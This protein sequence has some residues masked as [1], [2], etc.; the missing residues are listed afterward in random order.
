MPLT[1]QLIKS[2]ELR[3]NKANDKN[4]FS[5]KIKKIKYK[6]RSK[7]DPIKNTSKTPHF[8]E[9]I[10]IIEEFSNEDLAILEKVKNKSFED[11]KIF[12]LKLK[13]EEAAKQSQITE[14][15][16]YPMIKNRLAYNL[17]HQQEGALKILRDLDGRALLADEVG[18]GKTITAGMV[19]K[20]CIVRGFVRRALI[21]TPPSLVNQWKDE[22]STKFDLNFKEIN[23][24]TEWENIEL[25]IASIDKV[26]NFNVKANKFKHSKAHEIYWDIIIIDE[27]HKLKD[28]NTFRWKFIDRLQK[29]RLLLLTAT[30]FQN[31]LIE[32]YNLLSLLRRGHLG[33][34]SEFRSSFL[35]DGDER[36]PL[37]PQE[38]KRKLSEVMIRRRR[39]E[40]KG[41]HYMRRIPKIQSVELTW[42]ERRAYEEVMDLLLVHYLDFNGEPI[43][44]NLAA[45]SILPKITSSSKSSIE[46]LENLV[47]NPKYHK[48]TQ[49]I[50]ERIIEDFKGIGKDTKIESLMNLINEINKKDKGTKILL[51]TKH[52]ITLKYIAGILKKQRFKV[53][54]FKGGLTNDEKSKRINEFKEKTQILISTETGAEGLNFQFCSNLINYDLPWN[55]MSV[56]QRIGRLDRIGQ[57]HDINI[58]SLATKDTMEEHVVD[59]IINKMCCIGLVIGELPIILFNLGL[60]SPGDSSRPKIEEMLMDAFIDSKNNLSLFANDVKKIA[61]MVEQGIQEYNQSKEATERIL[62]AKD[63][64]ENKEEIK[65]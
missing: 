8:K 57:K 50:A 55:P 62:D 37:N 43:N 28:K 38:L 48:T 7:S 42:G 9:S 45:Y 35:V 26:K 30:P 1:L 21:L 27:A 14:L 3:T 33:T 19:L 24:E 54:E 17:P 5:K 23:K 15:I 60:D 65:I 22:L 20:E 46:F 44:T 39:D 63:K 4:M 16:S 53:T 47:K 2:K 6:S 10:K 52:P 49:D 29:K 51:Y 36:K 34:I 40:V 58:Y 61:S 64:L 13:S 18:L 11:I 25:A 31:D 41:I 12:D 59:L 56:E 32:L